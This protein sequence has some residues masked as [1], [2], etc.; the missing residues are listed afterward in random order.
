MAA[1]KFRMPDQSRIL[2]ETVDKHRLGGRVRSKRSRAGRSIGQHPDLLETL[3]SRMKH[4][5][6]IAPSSHEVV[7][8]AS[9]LEIPLLFLQFLQ[10]PKGLMAERDCASAEGG[11]GYEASV[12]LSLA[13]LTTRNP[14]RDVLGKGPNS[15]LGTEQICS[16]NP[17]N[18]SSS[19]VR[20]LVG[21]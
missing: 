16:Q 11:E 9:S 8:A 19:A 21:E 2:W 15:E 7:S 14:D 5:I 18:E 1:P 6:V 3:A 20:L 17:H 10:S 12:R 4:G 13:G